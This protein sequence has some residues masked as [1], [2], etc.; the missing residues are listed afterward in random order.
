MF[1]TLVVVVVFGQLWNTIIESSVFF[2]LVHVR[3]DV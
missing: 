2:V 3:F 1:V